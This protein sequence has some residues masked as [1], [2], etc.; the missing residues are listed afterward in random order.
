[1]PFFSTESGN[2]SLKYSNDT[3]NDFYGAF[4]IVSGRN[5]EALISTYSGKFVQVDNINFT[6]TATESEQNEIKTLLRN[7]VYINE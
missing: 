3:R 7:G 2:T 1:M 4:I 5:T 6:T